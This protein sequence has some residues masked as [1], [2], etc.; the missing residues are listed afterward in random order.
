MKKLAIA[1]ALIAPLT[2]AYAAPQA[3]TPSSEPSAPQHAQ[4]AKKKQVAASE[5]AP[6]KA[7]AASKKKTADSDAAPQKAQSVKKA[8]ASASS[9]DTAAPSHGS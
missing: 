4:N 8:A 7:Q 1:L 6:Q 9:A 5:S 2:V 3:S